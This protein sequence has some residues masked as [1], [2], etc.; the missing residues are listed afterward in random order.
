MAQVYPGR[1]P[2][3][4]YNG[5]LLT[6]IYP[7]E[8]DG[9]DGVSTPRKAVAARPS[10]AI[11][12]TTGGNHF[13]LT[14]NYAHWFITGDQFTVTGSAG[15]DGTYTV[16]APGAVW[17]GLPLNE[18][19]I[20]VISVP[21]AAPTPQGSVVRNIFVIEGDLIR[22]APETDPM[23]GD[24]PGVPPLSER[25]FKPGDAFSY[26]NPTNPT[27][28]R[29]GLYT[30]ASSHLSGTQTIVVPTTT[31]ASSLLPPGEITYLVPAS[32][33][34]N[35][36]GRGTVNYGERLAE[37]M[38]H[39]MENFASVTAPV[40]PLVG[41]LWYRTLVGS[42]GFLT[43]NGTAFTSDWDM[44]LGTLLFKDP[45][46]PSEDYKVSASTNGLA[47]SRT[48]NPT[49]GTNFFRV[50]DASGTELFAVKYSDFTKSSQK[51]LVSAD[52][53][54]IGATT[55]S[56]PANRGLS[57]ANSL[58]VFSQPAGVAKI[59]F[60]TGVTVNAD[61]RVDDAVAGKP[62]ALN[63]TV[64]ANVTL[65]NG[66][67][68]VLIG[69]NAP[70]GSEKARIIGQV[71][72]ET[73]PG[74]MPLDVTSSDVCVGLNAD[75]LDGHHASDFVVGTNVVHITGTE[76][77]TGNKTFSG[78]VDVPEPAA[79]TQAVTKNYADTITMAMAIVFG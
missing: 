51:F 66:G 39:I 11:K 35:I 8:V 5:T 34:L 33:S 63:S 68:A 4:L 78:T 47:V 41:Q 21:V 32:T 65:A 56:P 31:I 25:R 20:P 55:V 40:S 53:S 19:S 64:N 50:S 14:G 27:D 59:E 9:P 45:G 12:K 17:S 61:I 24:T 13:V 26:D 29:I 28:P 49:P 36:P 43:Y 2:I 44:N 77:I 37:D 60:A 52:G 73:S 42:E 62:L 74:T 38:V 6:H 58:A 48:S 30:V 69:A 22:T 67:G 7:Y 76:T 79:P 3:N 15:N 75:M 70:S 72:I 71:R 16:V 54:I 1:Y 23:P 46:T 18:T 10:I 57:V